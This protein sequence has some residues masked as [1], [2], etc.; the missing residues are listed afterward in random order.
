MQQLGTRTGE[1]DGHPGTLDRHADE[2]SCVFQDLYEYRQI[3]YGITR[4]AGFI[5]P[6]ALFS[7][8]FARKPAASRPCAM[9]KRLAHRVKPCWP[10]E[11]RVRS[12]PA[13]ILVF[14]TAAESG[15]WST[16]KSHQSIMQPEPPHELPD[17]SIVIRL[18]RI[19]DMVRCAD[20]R[21]HRWI[22]LET[23]IPVRVALA[24]KDAKYANTAQCS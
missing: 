18:L 20:C 3:P 1:R 24:A 10:A 14:A 8:L 15:P 17:I 13:S 2:R 7:G 19:R 6:A 22:G 21:R 16:R 5:R 9:T 23:G 12:V 11:A 4:I